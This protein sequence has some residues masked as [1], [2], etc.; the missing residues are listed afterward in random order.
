MANQDKKAQLEIARAEKIEHATQKLFVRVHEAH[1]GVNWER[2]QYLTGNTMIYLSCGLQCLNPEHWASA[3]A[4]GGSNAKNNALWDRHQEAAYQSKKKAQKAAK[5]AAKKAG[6]QAQKGSPGRDEETHNEKRPSPL[7]DHHHEEDHDEHSEHIAPADPLCYTKPS[8]T[9]IKA[10]Q[11][12]SPYFD[13]ERGRH[14]LERLEKIPACLNTNLEHGLN[15][16]F[17]S[18]AFS[19]NLHQTF[20]GAWHHPQ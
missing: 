4:T 6:K 12:V 8:D 20:G 3:L 15:E 7:Y 17:D 10:L 19:D 9:I 18:S 11:E 5:K 2:V 16:V 13:S 1:K 14:T